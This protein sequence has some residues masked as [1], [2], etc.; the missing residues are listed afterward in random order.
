MM[1][2]FKY[3]TEL[4]KDSGFAMFGACHITWLVVLFIFSIVLAAIYARAGEKE[5]DGSKGGFARDK[6][7]VVIGILLPVIS[8]YRDTVLIVTGHFSRYY[9][10]LHLCGMAL[11]IGSLYCFTRW[12]F[13]GVIYVLL[14]VPGAAAAL[15]FPDWVDYPFWNYMH[16]H[17]FISHGLIVAWGFSLIASGEMIPRWKELWMPVVFG[18]MGMAFIYPINN[19]L[20]TNYW[21]LDVPS[22]GSPLVTIAQVTGEKMYLL[23]YFIFVFLI[24]IL[25]MAVIRCA[26]RKM[27]GN[28]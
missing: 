16:I 3:V 17:D 2:Y 5:I 22:P 20:G 25:W 27:R 8:I 23:G 6:I 15:I 24:V 12:R 28:S 26:G 4:P 18:V 10:P 7:R 13:V 9:L 21:F 1:D 14:C 11:W 19:I